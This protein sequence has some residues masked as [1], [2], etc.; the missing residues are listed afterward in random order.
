[1][2]VTPHCNRLPVNIYR[3][4]FA[5][6][7]CAAAYD[8]AALSGADAARVRDKPALEGRLQWR[9][10][11]TVLAKWRAA[12]PGTKTCLSHKYDHAALALGRDKPGV[13]LEKLRKRDVRALAAHSFSAAECAWL[14]AHREPQL[15]FYQLW[16][17]KEALIK[18]EDLRFPGDLRRCGLRDGRV[19]SPRGT[20]Y[21]WISLM[22]DGQWLLAGVWADDGALPLELHIHAPQA[23]EAEV[24]A[25]NLDAPQVVWDSGFFPL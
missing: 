18:A 11:R 3:L 12:C 10:S 22:L 14:A 5:H 16:T 6:P 1:M 13:D 15:A 20:A 21:R 25:G 17:L 23:V 8:R 7:V 9:V 4:A 2:A 24:L 19:F